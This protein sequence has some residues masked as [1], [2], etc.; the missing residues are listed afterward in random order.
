[1]ITQRN[2]SAE[3]RA[4]LASS[5]A[6][7]GANES[8]VDQTGA[9]RARYPISQRDQLRSLG[10]RCQ[11]PHVYGASNLSMMFFLSCI[12]HDWGG[13]RAGFVYTHAS[14]QVDG[15]IHK[16]IDR[17]DIK[18]ILGKICFALHRFGCRLSRRALAGVGVPRERS[19]SPRFPHGGAAWAEPAARTPGELTPCRAE[20]SKC[21]PA[22]KL[23]SAQAGFTPSSSAQGT[24]ACA[25]A[26]SP[27]FILQQ[28]PARRLSGTEGLVSTSKI[29]Y[30]LAQNNTKAKKSY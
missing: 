22:C 25:G 26:S 17:T 11:K 9:H 20:A 6:E 29:Q 15:E 21:T 10:G 5:R 19:A 16:K 30:N 4:G 27:E 24:A 18:F 2:A 14:I 8:C 13:T 3:K 1:M 12:R 7:R 28:C 23:T